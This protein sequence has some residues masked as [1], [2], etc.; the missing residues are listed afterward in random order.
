MTMM[1]GRRAKVINRHRLDFAGHRKTP[2]SRAII[3]DKYLDRAIRQLCNLLHCE[4]NSIAELT[5]HDHSYIP[6]HRTTRNGDCNAGCTPGSHRSRNEPVARSGNH[7]TAI[8]GVTKIRSRN[9]NLSLPHV[10]SGASREDAAPH[11]AYRRLRCHRDGTVK[12]PVSEA[13]MRV[14]NS[15]ASRVKQALFAIYS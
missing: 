15:C 13:R 12:H 2:P 5:I 7:R 1:R 6:C 8:L 9:G 10:T 11:A 14:Y 4:Q 3:E